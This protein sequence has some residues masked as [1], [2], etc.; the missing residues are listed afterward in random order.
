MALAEI[1]EVG[2]VARDVGVQVD[3][4]KRSLTAVVVRAEGESKCAAASGLVLEGCDEGAADAL[5]TAVRPDDERV[6]LP[7]AAVV[8]RQ[9][10]DPAE[11]E[12]AVEGREGE[13]PGDDTIEFVGSGRQVGSSGGPVEPLD[14][15][16][17]GLEPDGARLVSEVGDDHGA[18]A[19]R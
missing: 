13:A 8:L 4:G 2:D 1:A 3:S 14:E 18:A 6:Q 5:K 19:V 17:R 11:Q 12:V 7:D 16:S 9:T 10:A 15:Q